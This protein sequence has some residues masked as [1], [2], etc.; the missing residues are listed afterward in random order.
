MKK[1][2][3]LISGFS[4]PKSEFKSLCYRVFNENVCNSCYNRHELDPGNWTWCPDH[5]NTDRMFE[6]TKNNSPEKVFEAIDIVRNTKRIS[7]VS[8]LAT[9]VNTK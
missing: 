6:C 8:N 3:I 4:N 7:L 9:P 1:P 5:E 2:T